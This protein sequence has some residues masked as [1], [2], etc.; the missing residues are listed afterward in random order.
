M[1]MEIRRLGDAAGA[2]V[3]GLDMTA[4][5]GPATA[6]AVNRAF[7]DHLVLVFRDQPLGPKQFMAFSR[8]FG[9]LQ[10]HV[11]KSYR[12]PEA[13]DIVMMTNVDNHGKFDEVGANRGVGWHSDLS[14]DQTPAKATLLH[15][16]EIPDRGGDTWFANMQ[17]AYAAMPEDMKNRITG[18]AALFRYGGRHG[19]SIEHLTAADRAKPNVL[20]PVVRRH[21][22]SGIPSV[23]VNPYH[24]VRIVG[25]PRAESDALLDAVF[26][27]CDRP[28]FQWRHRW[29]LGDTII[30][31]N[32][33][34]VHSGRLD[35]PLDQRRIFMRATV[36][37][38]NT[39]TEPRVDA[40]G[41]ATSMTFNSETNRSGND[42]HAE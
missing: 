31:E 26:E 17:R 28:E 34:A 30:W 10:P 32:R 22:E 33:A 5:W 29:R 15:A 21:P 6:A 11:A 4:P 42:L 14:Y 1:T 16:V 19:M 7:L 36:R 9:A 23:Y 24:A 25:M 27:W 13:P 18:R 35:Y 20:H 8:N 38:T 41:S 12:H 37:G 3:V 2:E 40:S 39:L